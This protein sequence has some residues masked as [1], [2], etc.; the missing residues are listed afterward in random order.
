MTFA[1]WE[2]ESS[3][4]RL[5]EK[6]SIDF[7]K[8]PSWFWKRSLKWPGILSALFSF[9]HHQTLFN[10]QS[11]DKSQQWSDSCGN[12]LRAWLRSRKELRLRRKE[13]VRVLQEEEYSSRE[14]RKGVFLF[15]TIFDKPLAHSSSVQQTK[16]VPLLGRSISSV[17]FRA[18]NVARSLGS[19]HQKWSPGTEDL[20]W[21]GSQED[22]AKRAGGPFFP[23]S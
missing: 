5:Q 7:R 6:L 1:L 4:L 10:K 14:N 18:P 12:L 23:L 22:G 15:E 16:T 13:V 9:S 2:L 3:V 11:S 8:R 20:E 17:P 21:R 19:R